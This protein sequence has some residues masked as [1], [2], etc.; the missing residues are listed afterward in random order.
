[1]IPERRYRRRTKGWRS[2]IIDDIIFINMGAKKK[3]NT[4]NQNLLKILLLLKTLLTLVHS[5]AMET[6][7]NPYLQWKKATC[8]ETNRWR[9]GF[10]G[11]S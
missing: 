11:T 10:Y 9:E 4:K 2:L 6:S 1:L 3:T 5:D 8:P 7:Q